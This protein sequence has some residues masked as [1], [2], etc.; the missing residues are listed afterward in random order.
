VDLHS[1]PTL[2]RGANVVNEREM[3]VL[4]G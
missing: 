3:F 4:P 2:E 1:N